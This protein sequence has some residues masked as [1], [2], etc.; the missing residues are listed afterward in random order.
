MAFKMKSPFLFDTLREAKKAAKE[1]QKDR[2]KKGEI[3]RK[4]YKQAKK[5][6]RKYKD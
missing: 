3:T 1:L 2:F 6:I 4:Q 5:E